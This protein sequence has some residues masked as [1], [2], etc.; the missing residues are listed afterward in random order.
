MATVSLTLFFLL[1][2]LSSFSPGTVQSVIFSA[3]LSADLYVIIIFIGFSMCFFKFLVFMLIKLKLLQRK[4]LPSC[5]MYWGWNSCY[6]V[7][8]VLRLYMNTCSQSSTHIQEQLESWEKNIL[9]NESSP[10]PDS[11]KKSM[12]IYARSCIWQVYDLCESFVLSLREYMNC[13]SKWHTL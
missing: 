8:L 5:S 10:E 9:I 11:Q 12:C 13:C 1:C 4:H 3:L 2:I 6:S 7:T